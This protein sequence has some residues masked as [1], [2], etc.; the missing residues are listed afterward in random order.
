MSTKCD[1]TVVSNRIFYEWE[2]CSS[3]PSLVKGY[4]DAYR[5]TNLW[6]VIKHQQED[7]AF[8]ECFEQMSPIPSHSRVIYNSVEKLSNF[9]IQLARYLNAIGVM[10]A[11]AIVFEF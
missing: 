10:V 7:P 11:A 6:A 1:P 5:K 8:A 4:K 2:S 3:D 9:E